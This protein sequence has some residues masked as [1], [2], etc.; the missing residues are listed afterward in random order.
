M[1]YPAVWTDLHHDDLI[2]A[3]GMTYPS[4]LGHDDAEEL[5]LHQLGRLT[6]NSGRQHQR[7]STGLCSLSAALALISDVF[8]R[9]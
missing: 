7:Y 5:P 2:D 6:H 9:D 8:C 3:D 1:P 4:Q